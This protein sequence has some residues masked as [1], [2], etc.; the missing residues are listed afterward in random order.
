MD[1]REALGA[2]LALF[3]GV[4]RRCTGVLVV[5]LCMLLYGH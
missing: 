5:W 3:C 1:H 4:R 2:V